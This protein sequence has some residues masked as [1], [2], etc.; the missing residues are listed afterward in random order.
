MSEL[1]K[2]LEVL[3]ALGFDPVPS[4][5]FC[6]ARVYSIIKQTAHVLSDLMRN[7]NKEKLQ[8]SARVSLSLNDE[9]SVSFVNDLR[10]VLGLNCN[11]N[12]IYFDYLIFV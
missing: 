4:N 11:F 8:S 6:F 5:P 12:H 1:L 3:E 7:E 9:K 2:P 10:D